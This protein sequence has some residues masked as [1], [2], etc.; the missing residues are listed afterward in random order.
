[1]A[2]MVHRRNGEP[3]VAFGSASC[4]RSGSDFRQL[5]SHRPEPPIVSPLSTPD[6]GKL[7]CLKPSR[8][9]K[10]PT[11]FEAIMKSI[12]CNE[13]ILAG[14]GLCCPTR[15][16]KKK[17]DIERTN[18][19]YDRSWQSPS[20]RERG[21]GPGILWQTMLSGRSP[22]AFRPEF[23]HPGCTNIELPLGSERGLSA[24]G[25]GSI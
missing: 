23:V 13:E 22:G 18:S 7:R 9:A 1:M 24:A 4:L 21:T 5:S 16:D 19:E 20:N 6:Q 25:I 15:L 2:A 14:P 8:A 10:L 3:N 12:P 17:L 11:L